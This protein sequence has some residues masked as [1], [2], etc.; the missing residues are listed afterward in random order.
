MKKAGHTPVFHP[1]KLH[2]ALSNPFS[3]QILEAR[4]F[5]L[6]SSSDGSGVYEEWKVLEVVDSWKTK[7]YGV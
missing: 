4:L 3:R 7:R 2:L 1:L 5:I 6:V